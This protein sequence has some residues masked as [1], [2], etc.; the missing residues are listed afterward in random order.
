VAEG[1]DAEGYAADDAGDAVAEAFGLGALGEEL[2]FVLGDEIDVV[3]H[4]RLGQGDTFRVGRA[5]L[6]FSWMRWIA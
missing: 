3:L 6:L 4:M 1:R 2:G 5:L